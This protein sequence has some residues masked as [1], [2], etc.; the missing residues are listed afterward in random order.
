MLCLNK[1]ELLKNIDLNQLKQYMLYD[2]KTNN[3]SS[4]NLTFIKNYDTNTNTT[5]ESNSTNESN[6]ITPNITNSNNSKKQNIVV[7]VGVPRNRV[8]INY[9]KKYSKYNEPFKINNHKNFADKL[10]WIFYKII[11]NL[12][13]TDL[14]HI[15]SFKIMKEFKIASVEK[16]KNQKNILKDFKIQ[17]SAVE[18]DLTNNE[19]ISFRTFHALC[20]LYLVN[21]I[22][23][24]DNNT[25]CVLCTNEDEKVINLQNYK[26]LKITNVKMS[27]QFNNFDI[28]LANNSITE[29]ELQKILKSYYVIENIEKP[30]KAFSNYKLDDLVSI[31][32][33]LSINIYDE[34]AKKKKK[35][36]LYENIIQKLI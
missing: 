16:L 14:E 28:E 30:L 18:D 10:F 24:R 32:E 8:Q 6:I 23:I 1:E 36:E 20:V 25:Y 22:V 33:K 2:L 15:N 12:N 5:N 4:K 35:Q 34:H 21:V 3:N 13:D 17:K 26:L 27:S 29:E 31:A 19:K 11:N 9:S 7:N